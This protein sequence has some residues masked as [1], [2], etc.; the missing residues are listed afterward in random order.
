MNHIVVDLEMN[1]ITKQIRDSYKLS[2]ELI[3]IGAVKMNGAF[4]VIDTYQTYVSPD[5]GKMDEK[6]IQLT[7]ITDE[8]LVGAPKFAVAMD[9]FAKWIGKGKTQYYSWSMS[10][11]RQFQNE[12]EFKGY[13]GG[14]IRKMEVSWN[15]FQQEYSRLLG[16]E[17][18]IKLIKHY[19]RTVLKFDFKSDSRNTLIDKLV[20]GMPEDEFYAKIINTLISKLKAISTN[21]LTDFLVDNLIDESVNE[22]INFISYLNEFLVSYSEDKDLP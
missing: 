20:Q 16:I 17:K 19:L 13:Q 8:K 1:K 2:S 21:E 15:D 18:K 22:N 6:I 9:D 3:E 14:I 7:G 5:F 4:E 10:D 11:I 12:A